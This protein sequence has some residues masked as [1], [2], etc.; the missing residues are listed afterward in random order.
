MAVLLWLIP[1]AAIA[2]LLVP[3]WRVRGTLD[4]ALNVAEQ[5]FG[6]FVAELDTRRDCL[7]DL[8]RVCHV[9]EGYGRTTLERLLDLHKHL[10]RCK[11]LAERVAIENGISTFLKDLVSNLGKNNELKRNVFLRQI[12]D[13]IENVEDVVA[14]RRGDFNTQ[15]VRFNEQ[16]S[17]FIASLARRV[18]RLPDLRKLEMTSIE[19]LKATMPFAEMETARSNAASLV[20]I[21]D[22]D[23]FD[24]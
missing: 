24:L 2:A 7:P 23:P 11:D 15:V 12:V 22:V 1:I 8:V 16:S 9:F 17:G 10:D 18:W 13:R 14:K 21:E 3:V 20:D 4:T 5:S 6:S 19:L